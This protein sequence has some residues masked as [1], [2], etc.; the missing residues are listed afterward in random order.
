MPFRLSQRS[1][2]V[3]ARSWINVQSV[4][5]VRQ[6]RQDKTVHMPLAALV[7]PMMLVHRI[8][9]FGDTIGGLGATEKEIALRP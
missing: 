7:E 1:L 6:C 3:C 4:R 5:Q 2:A 8:K 9:E